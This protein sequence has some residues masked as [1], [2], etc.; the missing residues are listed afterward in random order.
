[1]LILGWWVGVHWRCEL[2]FLLDCLA[3]WWRV[4]LL[5]L[6]V[7]HQPSLW[8]KK[9]PHWYSHGSFIFNDL[10]VSLCDHGY[11]LTRHHRQT[12]DQ[13]CLLA[14]EVRHD[15]VASIILVLVANMQASLLEDD[16][17][18]H[19]ISWY[20]VSFTLL[21]INLLAWVLERL[22]AW[23]ALTL[24]VACWFVHPLFMSGCFYCRSFLWH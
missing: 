1:M 15:M 22:N 13:W 18:R 14:R 20:E 24:L 23:L 6:S 8:S 17:N 16:E 3:A 12:I 4:V 7:I 21:L 19:Q 11:D 9:E 2:K 10:R 5:C